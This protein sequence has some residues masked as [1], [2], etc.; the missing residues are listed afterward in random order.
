MTMSNSRP[1][2]RSRPLAFTGLAGAAALIALSPGAAQAQ[3]DPL[4]ELSRQMIGSSFDNAAPSTSLPGNPSLVDG[5]SLRTQP[6]VGNLVDQEIRRPMAPRPAT[7]GRTANTVQLI[8]PV[9][10][11]LEFA[12]IQ[13]SVPG[14][15]ILEMNGGVFV[16][17]SETSRALPAYLKGRELQASLGV[18]FQLAYSDNHPD[19]DLA[20]MGPRQSDIARAPAPHPVAPPPQP[21]AS[22]PAEPPRPGRATD[23]G[24]LR[25]QAPWAAEQAA[26]PEP[27]QSAPAALVAMA[28][29]K[30]AAPAPAQSAAAATVAVAAPAAAQPPAP[31]ARPLALSVSAMS[32]TPLTP[33]PQLQPV[34]AELALSTPV[35]LET[36]R[37][38]AA[39]P[40]AAAPNTPVLQAVAPKAAAPEPAQFAAAATEA[41]TSSPVLQAPAP[42]PTF[43]A[44]VTPET[45]KPPT[46]SLPSP[47][48]PVAI[49][50]ALLGQVPILASSLMAVN[51]ELAYVYVK[52]RDEAQLAA[53]SRL[54]P[55]AVVH[56]R[57][58]ELLAQ[59][60]VYRATRIGQRLQ[61]AQMSQLRREGFD[62]ALVP[63]QFAR[64]AELG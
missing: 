27:A 25:L 41:V 54:A 23:L 49:R 12:Q 2:R 9:I 60:G 39:A 56:E 7:V 59:V 40:Q 62:L 53:V 16:L 29:P 20:W 42:K 19:L 10:T 18:T 13:Q 33:A 8:V 31:T 3:T 55:V 4:R 50:P 58:G 32:E 26:A 5:G 36:Q 34:A 45:S 37:P 24:P 46:A 61:E 28:A 43:L 44:A 35:E 1:P 11:G 15:K 22:K 17:V 14:A 64:P 52:V 21:L 30:A 38:L 48:Q 57:N 6:V 47:V 63:Q 51:Q